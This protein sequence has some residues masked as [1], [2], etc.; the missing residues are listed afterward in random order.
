MSDKTEDTFR[1]K[2]EKILEKLDDALLEQPVTETEIGWK[3]WNEKKQEYYDQALTSII[4]LVDESLPPKIDEHTPVNGVS[5]DWVA[6]G[7]NYAVDKMR[8][9]IRSK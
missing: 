6:H 7:N 1:D 2:A 3:M 9:I 4:N 5:G 8:A